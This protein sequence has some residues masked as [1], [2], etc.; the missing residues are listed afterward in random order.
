MIEVKGSAISTIGR[1]ASRRMS[2]ATSLLILPALVLVGFFLVLPYLNM[3]YISVMTPSYQAVFERKLTFQNYSHNLM[4][5]FIW[6][7]IART[8]ELGLVTVLV[9]LVISYPA[10]YHLARQPR[11]RRGLLMMLILTPLLVGVVIRTYGWMIILAD[12]GLINQALHSLHL[13]AAKL[14]YN[15]TGVLIGLVQIYVPYMVLALL[16]P[17]QAI[18][19]D[20]E[21]AARSLGANRWRVFWRIT[22]PL[23]LPGVLSGSILVFVL[24]ISAYIIPQLLGG[25]VTITMP[26][27]VVQEVTDLL[28]WPEGS[29]LTII[30]FVA[31]I[32]ILAVYTRLMAYFMRGLS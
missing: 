8:V 10:A 21:S 24:A 15:T 29:A 23:S 11:R 17:L 27:L 9:S 28:N 6:Q 25:F 32:A 7:V 1:A 22:W 13:P 16:A 18:D 26:I 5:P 4:D 31:A 19:P 3:L 2:S 14:M 12:T 30:F 20:L